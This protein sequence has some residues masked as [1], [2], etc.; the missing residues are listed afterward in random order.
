MSIY[1]ALLRGI[2]VGGNN[3]IKM[4]ELK[5]MFE[6]LGFA[7]VQTY[8][9]SGN[10]IFESNENANNLEEKIEK[11]ISEVFGFNIAVILRTADELVS[12]IDKSPFNAAE[13]T[14]GQSIHLTLLKEAPTQEHIN[15]LPDVDV[16][17]D[18]YYISG[19]EIYVLYRNSILDSK[20][21]K[22]FQSLMPATARNWKT[23]MKL[24]AMAKA[25]K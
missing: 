9:N 23:I 19:K 2:N 17:N 6:E 1:F 10:V 22:K 5:R 15:N 25:L 21:P 3:M 8:I 7:R 12:I 13:L 4:A 18:E 24:D 14:E 20:L 11:Q 16:G